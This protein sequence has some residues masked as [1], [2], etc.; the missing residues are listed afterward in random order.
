MRDAA[1]EGGRAAGAVEDLDRPDFVLFDV[2]PGPGT[3]TDAVAVAREV[4]RA[5][6]R[7]DSP[8][9]IKT[10]GKTGLHV[11]TPWPGPGGH[12]AAR[13]W[14]LEIA[15]RVVEALPELAT[16]QIR[17]AKR[18]A[19]VY[20]DVMQNVRA[21]HAVPPYVLRAVPGATASTPLHW[22]E[23]TP[24]LDPAAFTMTALF[25]GLARQ[26]HDPLAAWSA[27]GRGRRIGL[28]PSDG[29]PPPPGADRLVARVSAPW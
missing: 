28:R 29:R 20:L 13:A 3:F 4:H 23:V 22:R 5:L 14:A 17:K 8:A 27:R 1:T 24:D 18:G 19:R 21:H 7:E 11:L 2:D 10:S 6:K 26:K 16:T 9:F 12:D 15:E 25:R